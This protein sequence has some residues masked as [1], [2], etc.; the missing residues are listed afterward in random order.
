MITQNS[1]GKNIDMCKPVKLV[2]GEKVMMSKWAFAKWC[3]VTAAV[4][5]VSTQVYASTAS[6]DDACAAAYSGNYNGQDGDG[7][8]GFGAWQVIPTSN[9]GSSGA[10]IGSSQNNGG[11]CNSGNINCN[12]S[13]NKS[14]GMYAN[15]GQASGLR[16]F[17]GG[18]VVGQTFTMEMDNGNI[19][20]PYANN[21]VVEVQLMNASG[22]RRWGVHFRGGAGEYQTYD[23]SNLSFE[24]GTGLGF[25]DGGLRIAFTLTGAN[26]YSVTLTRITA[27]GTVTQTGTLAASGDIDRVFVLVRS[28]GSGCNFDAFWNKM[29]ISACPAGFP[30]CSVTKSSGIDT[31]NTQNTFDAPSGNTSYSWALSAN[32][33]G[34]S[35]SGSSTSPNVTVNNGTTA[36]SYTITVTINN[37]GCISSCSQTITVTDPDVTPPTVTCPPQY[38]AQCGIPAVANSISAFVSQGGTASD[39]G[40]GSL[41]LQH[42]GDTTISGTGCLGSPLVIE[43]VYRVYDGSGNFTDCT[44]LIVLEDTQLP[45]ITC[46]AGAT[47]SCISLLPAVN[48]NLVTASD[49]CGAATVTH[50]GDVQSNPGSSC[51]NTITRTYRATDDCGNFSECTQVF[52]I[53]DTTAPTVACDVNA[54][55]NGGNSAYSDG[56]QNGDNGGTGLGAWTLQKTSGDTGLNGHFMGNSTGNNTAG[57]TNSDGDIGNPAF[58]L[59]ANSGNLSDAWRNFNRLKVG[60]TFKFDFDNCLID[61]GGTVGIGLQN[62]TGGANRMEL[63]FVGGQ[64]NYKLNDGSGVLDTG[65]PFTCEGLRVEVKLLTLDT[66]TITITR[67]VNGAVT[68]ISG[69]SLAGTA[70]SSV[71]RFRVFNF[72]AGAGSS[73]NVLVNNISIDRT[74]RLSCGA[75]APDVTLGLVSSDN[76]GTPTVT[77]SPAV[78]AALPAGNSSITVTVSDSCGN[79]AQCVIPVVVSDTVAPVITCPADITVQCNTSTDPSNTGSATANDACDGAVTPTYTDSTAAGSC[80]FAS[81]IT[82]T[83]S[84][85]DASGN[86]ATCIQT[87]SVV[88]TTAP[89][90]TAPADATLTCTDSTNPSA[91]GT[92]TATDNCDSPA[93]PAP[94]PTAWI[95]EFHYDNTGGDVGEFVEIAGTAGLTFGASCSVVL[96]N[97][98]GGAP[99]LTIPL[100]GMTIPDAGCGIGTISV[101]ATGLQNGAP[102]GI[103]LALC[104]GGTVSEFISYEGTFTAVGGPANGQLSVDVG[105]TQVGTEPVGSSIHKIGTGNTGAAFTWAKTTAG[106]PG[107]ING[108]QTISPCYT[109]GGGGLTVSYSDSTAGTCPIVITR[110]W[111]AT[112]SCGNSGS[113]NQILTIQD[114]TAPTLSGVPANVTVQ[115]SAVP[116]PAT[117]TASDACDASPTV[118]L[119]ES[120]VAGSCAGNYVLTRTWTATDDCGNSAN[121]S[122]VITV[123]DTT[124][125]VLTLPANATV[126]CTGSTDPSATGTA[127][128]SD[129][130]SGA[131][132]SYSDSTAAGSCPQNSVITRTWTATDG[133][134]NVSS[135]NQIINVVDSTDPVVTAPANVTVDCT[136]STDPSNTGSASATDNCDTLAG[137]APTPT[138]W[139]N[140]FHYDNSGTD[141]GEFVEIAGTAGITFGPGCS[142]TFY[143]GSG[144]ASYGSIPLNGLTIPDE[145]CGIGTLSFAAAGLQNGSP[146]GIALALCLGGTVSEFISYEGTFTAVG[147][148]AAGMLSVDVGVTQVGTEPV[149]SSIHRIGSGNTGAAFTWAKTTAG[150]PGSINGGQTISPC[151]TGGG[152]GLTISFSDS[153][154]GTCPAVITRTWTATDACGN[155]GSSV[156]TITVQDTTAPSLTVPANTSVECDGDSSPASTGSASATDNCDASP[157]ITFSDATAAGSCPQASVITRTWTATDACGNSVSG[158][159]VINVVDSTQPVVS[160]PADV[161]VSCTDSIDP[162]ATGS[163]SATDNCDSLALPA[164]PTTAWI[165]EFHYD[166]NSGDVGEFVEVAGT[167]GITFS[168]NCVITLYNGSGGAPYL[169]IPLNGLT[170]PDEGCGYGAISVAAPGLQNGAPDG[171][172]LAL[173]LGGAVAEFISYE[174][175][176]TAV[177]GPANGQTS[178]DVGVSQV[179][180]EPIGSSIHK[181]GS[182]NNGAAF[183]WAKTTAATPGTINGGQTI[184]PCYVTGGGT[185]TISYSDASAGTCPIVVTRTWTATD[186]CGNSGS[187]VQT[188]TIVDDVEPNLSVPAE[189]TVECDSD[190]STA[191][192]GVATATDL[193]DPAPVIASDDDVIPGTCAGQYTIERFWSATDNCGNVAE[194]SQ[195]INVV[196]T[197]APAL[198]VP[199]NVTVECDDDSSPA[200][201]GSASASDNC[202]VAPVISYSDSTVP[203]PCDFTATITRTW[204]AT[205]DCGNESSADQIITVVDTTA[206]VLTVPANIEIE[207]DESSDPSNTGTATA[208]DNC[209]IPGVSYSDSS[210]GTCPT[211]ITRTWTATDA[212]GNSSSAD[213][214]IT[215]GDSFAPV[216]SGCPSGGSVVTFGTDPSWRAS[217]T[218]GSLLGNAQYVCLQSSVPVNC[219]SGA[220]VYNFG[221]GGWGADVSSV[222]G[223]GWIWAPGITASTAPAF[224]AEYNFTK[225]FSLAQL[226]ELA[227]VSMA[228]DDFAEI[229]VNGLPVGSMGSVSDGNLAG[230]AQ[231]LTTFDILPFIVVGQNTITIRA[232]NGN[233]GCGAG[234]YGCNPAGVIAGVKLTYDQSLAVVQTYDC[235]DNVPAPATV[236]AVDACNGVIAVSFTETQSAPGTSCNNTITRTWVATDSCGNSAICSEIINVQDTTAPV[237]NVPADVTVEC[238]DPTDSSATGTATATDNCSAS[239]TITSSDS[240]AEGACPQASII[241]RTWTATDDCGNSSSGVQIINVVD[242]TAPAV[243]APADVTIECTESSAP[244]NTGSGSVTDNCDTFAAPAPAVTAWINEFHY[245]NSGADIG[246]FVEIAGTAGIT[247]GPSC[248][249]TFYNGSG[250]ASYGSIALNGLT[251][252]D[253]G[254]GIG[255][256]SFPAP[257]LQNGSPDGIALALCLGGTV[258]E[259][260]SYEGTFTAVG[261]PAAGQTS[262]DVGVTQTGSEPAGS[263]IHKIGSGNTG[264][265]FTWAKTTAA[266]PGA[267]NGGQTISPCYTGSSG[268]LTLSYSDSTAGTCPTV[269]TRTWTG[270]DG[271]GNVGTADQIIT[272][273]DTTAPILSGVPANTTVECDSIPSA[274]VVTAADAC[275]P[276]PSVNFSET[277]TAGAC[278]NSYTITRTW[279]ATDNCGNSSAGSQVISV[280]DTTGPVLALPANATVECTDSTDPSATGSATATD[281]CAGSVS[282]SYSD[283]TVAGS[284]PQASVITR[285][286]TATDDCGNQTSGSQIIN[287]VDSTD[288]VVTAP[289]DATVECDASI[290]PSATGSATATDNCDSVATDAA[291]LTAWINEFHYDNSGSDVGEFVEIAGTAGITFGPSCSITLYNGSGGAPYS[292]I[293]LN[294]M[295]IPDAGCGFG[296]ISVATPGL[297]NGSPDGIALA[298]C[299]GGTVSEF[300]SYEG[301]FTA[302]GGI[303]NGQTSVDVGVAQTGTEPA[304]SS[305]HKVG[306]G[307]NGA[308]FIWAKTTAATPGAINGGQIISPCYTSGSGTMTITYSD[309]AS[310]TCPTIVTRTWT[311]T[312]GCGNSGSANQIITVVD[313]TAPVISVPADATVECDADNSP[314]ATGSATA[315][316]NC[317]SAPSIS[318]SDVVAEGICPQASVITRTWTA[319]DDCGNT[320]SGVQTIHVV[321]TT[322]PVVV[323]PADVEVSCTDSIAP[324][325]T[326][327]ASATDNCDSIGSPAP[328]LTAW[329]NEFHYD[330]NGT[331]AGEFVEIAGTAGITFGPACQITLYNGSGGASYA[332]YPLN[333]L[334]IPDEGCGYGTIS[335]ATPGLQNGAPDGIALALCLGGTVAEFI[336]YEGTFTAVGGPAAGMLSVDVGVSQTATEPVGSSIHRIGSGNTGTNFTWAKTTANSSG[337][338]NVGQSIAPC[339]V[340][341]GG[342]LILTYSDSSAGACPE[343]VTRT[344]TAT[345][346]CGNVGTAV[347]TITIV[348]ENEPLL[349]VPAEVTVECDSDTSAAATGFA[350]AT[351]NCDSSPIIES[352][353]DVV[354]G[355]CAGQYTIERFWSAKDSCGNVAEASQIINVVDTTAPVLTVPADVTVECSDDSSPAGT[356]SAT[357][358]DNCGTVD[359]T[360]SDS[361]AAGPCDFTATIT[362]TWTATDDCGNSVSADQI[363]TV[364]DTTAPVVTV[365]ADVTIECDESSDPSNTGS[366]TA[367]DNCDTP[368]ITYSD[369]VAGSCPSVITRTW[370]ATDA[371][372]NSSSADQII[373]VVDTTAPSLSVPAD[374]TVECTGDTSPAATGSA[375]GSD[376]CGSVTITSSDSS[377]SGCGDTETITRTWTATDE[378]GNS[379][380]A[381]QVI[382]VVDT[383]A[384]SISVPADATVECTG[385]TSP[386][387]TGSAT[388]SDSCGSVTITSSDSSV[389]GCGDT[390]TITRT[391]TATDECGNSTSADQIITVVDTTAPSLSVP[392]DATVECTG[393]TSPAATGSATGSDSCGSVTITSSDSSVAGCGNTETITRTWT[394]TDECGNS[395]SAD[396]VITVVDT[397]APSLSV[398]ADATVECTGDTS[399][400]GTG[401]ATGSDSCGSVTIT[402]SDSSVAGCGSSETIT[403]TWTA[404]DEC[405][406]STSADQII[407]VVDTTAPSISVPA[408]ATVECTGDT[409]PAATGSAT[410]SDSCGSVTITSSDSSVA[411]CGDTETITR[412][413]TATDACGNSTS[414]DQVITVVDTTA[415][416]IS[417]PADATVE[418]TGDT[419]P[420]STGSATG[421]DSCGSVTISSSDSSVAGCGNTETITRTWTAT[422]ACGNTASAVQTITV[423]DTTA[424]SISVP[425]DATVE[426]T[427]DTSPASTGSAT[428]S[429]SCGSVTI[430]SSDSSVAGCGNSATITRTWTATDACGNTASAAQTITVVDTTAPTLIGVP[431]NT[432]VECDAV[433]APAGVT[434]SDTCGSAT[435]SFSQSSSGTCPTV[436]TRTWTATDACGN[437]ASASQ[438]ITVQDTTA[439]V[440][441][442]PANVTAICAPGASDPASSGYATA[443]DNCGTATV[444]YSDSISG[445]CPNSVI[446]RTWTATDE[447]GNSSSCQQIITLSDTAKPIL[448]GCPADIVIRPCDPIPAPAT[449]T[450]VDACQGALTVTYSQVTVT[451]RIENE[452]DNSSNSSDS[453]D[454]NDGCG[455]HT[456][457]TLILRTWTATDACG[458]SA[459]CSQ[460]ITVNNLGNCVFSHGYWKTH[461]SEWPVTSLTLGCTTYNQSQL[462]GI[463]NSPNKGD[464]SISLAQQLIAALLNQAA[465][466]C[467]RS[468]VQASIDSAMSLLCTKPV[469][470]NPSGSI[471]NQMNSAACLLDDF[472]NGKKGNKKCS[473]APN[474]P[475]VAMDDMETTAQNT[476]VIISILDNDM[477]ADN[478]SLAVLYVTNPSSGTLTI[479]ANGTIT[480]TPNNGYV[481]SDS[482]TYVVS[483]GRGGYESAVV[484]VFVQAGVPPPSSGSCTDD[485]QSCLARSTVYFTS[486][487]SSG[488]SK[489]VSFEGTVTLTD[490]NLASDFRN[491]A[492][493]A[494]G[495]LKVKVAGNEIYN[496]VAVPYA[497]IG[498]DPVANSEKWEFIAG[499]Y[500]KVTFLWKDS[501]AYDANRDPGLPSNLGKFFTRFIHA[502]ETEFRFEWKSSTKKPLLIVVDGIVI[503]KRDSSGNVSSTLPN[504]KSSS[505]IDVTYPARLVP[506]NTISWYQDSNPNDGF[507]NLIYSHEATADGISA[508]T[509]FN[510]GGQFWMTLPVAGLSINSANKTA[511]AELT[512]GKTTITLVGCTEFEVG[513]YAKSGKSW[514]YQD[515]CQDCNSDDDSS[516]NDSH[517]NNCNNHCGHYGHH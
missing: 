2:S 125:P 325:A 446:T 411:G 450:A 372:G 137:P 383:T 12:T 386:A 14:W 448:S 195:I 223:A 90:V 345:D 497:V 501:Q 436:I 109:G 272:V 102:D 402:S 398:P 311:A 75:T 395:T 96:Y 31:A 364:V 394:A 462:L 432:S 365:P 469:G 66:Y 379:T 146:D 37:N 416:S 143:N 178:V 302:V 321:D 301:T 429:D 268:S 121:A 69:R 7:A 305:I 406:N 493:T 500:E 317:D 373:T 297:Q 499:A 149:G 259:F 437:T 171:I 119:S 303:A 289:A 238:T 328:A 427:G 250:G 228:A 368:G 173:C 166:N 216:L 55:D 275:D 197:T 375:T 141:V 487:S 291:P 511:E 468:D 399:P 123:Q 455:R 316:D 327:N 388:G 203:G 294:G 103:A 47:L 213:Q 128:A 237:L 371:C 82:R 508:D 127:T 349:V 6:Y 130:C 336:S 293:S 261:G 152:G 226:P 341:S 385:D 181:I 210:S 494:Q 200:G 57:D 11:G 225:K 467:V 505:R 380:S 252:P 83:W 59:Y 488:A 53:N 193:C 254:C 145:G 72:N 281:N 278:A 480:Y 93:T 306:S 151:F 332:S 139:I 242:T 300:I 363:I 256:L 367:T 73:R 231:V 378:C 451:N 517:D 257:G 474:H 403:R 391:W 142:I 32:T 81:T 33:S 334:T 443:T 485:I 211:V 221:S 63:Y 346:G 44:Q 94:T 461:A 265:A 191:A 220:L 205:D 95:N 498:A 377:V 1:I 483:D 174:G 482:F 355:S 315:T 101:A 3:A 439:P 229:I 99:Y 67:L 477:D 28:A 471:R 76:C 9:G 280:V 270:T 20:G 322:D 113:A 116:A 277:T 212:C 276:N 428:G 196:D 245:D 417:V 131:S 292:T 233:F 158:D 507:Q 387:A 329:I 15:S 35:I 97:G 453:S 320:A 424:P 330:N 464:A 85:T 362:R 426:C 490:G 179:G 431:A 344:W 155:S 447:C 438:V 504:S 100:S 361:V 107:A 23:A 48:V 22:V 506:G 430:T 401:S 243:T 495:S 407:T 484:C 114:V 366:A 112:D 309:S 409:S 115:C 183:T 79:S 189:I 207:C 105:V 40:P 68:T 78:G 358:S 283:S 304:G 359:V 50:Q 414:A 60:Q 209:D 299:L 452:D 134:G 24:R 204:T 185:L 492:S 253:E 36:G 356:G 118:T 16:T 515:D 442:C 163:A 49:N 267:I 286:W 347:Q 264:A 156:Q 84:A 353:D 298:L 160:A 269:I 491:N 314:A 422:D 296:T 425:A 92:A 219:P 396:Q 136:D 454:D 489:Y 263:S 190:T 441:T 260:I 162:S 43:R 227:T 147:G 444:T 370:T 307:N 323:A 153:T 64:P 473:S 351:D 465:G 21:N 249:I 41:S 89:V 481:G 129:N 516:D 54:A 486:S 187:S 343:V 91:T 476:P 475:P 25:T 331:D 319:T 192:T 449:V 352:D 419:S 357:A 354:P 198:T 45:V 333:G 148:P 313:T 360:S 290:D 224:P 133:C 26:T 235:I 246:E 34:A 169:T 111:T 410:G 182:G 46:P 98:S 232:A 180:T 194:A 214:I 369:S 104:V 445:N 240:T 140:E 175:T 88:D 58:G 248:T 19:N 201:T 496:N 413:W 18:L 188:I 282:I 86:T 13:G 418:C 230:N 434:A 350:T 255:T 87:I 262:V 138:A 206:P 384:P 397:T 503:A 502:T 466:A 52:V 39:S 77:Q 170:I 478:D 62:S 4:L 120:T 5:S 150:T 132:V 108:G 222:P 339:Y 122:Q 273:Q 509:Y 337:S 239:V 217:N 186:G 412:T 338:L 8:G 117:V 324:S 433:P 440:I 381:D 335:V 42:L 274:P 460:V 161:E 164:P 241:T 17:S 168:S 144:G 176:F 51:N 310:G 106:T 415:P 271:C 167:A 285:T 177:G 208:T 61:T 124:A 479:N 199:A 218:S 27:G 247:F 288:P 342:T 244:S 251:I 435:V 10:F 74:V 184:S 157:V 390:E 513:S 458:N 326:G 126:E 376:N 340:A 38:N 284:C 135:G 65:I 29:Q 312:D 405:G 70:G 258:S 110:T 512:I 393:D 159:Q 457:N 459:S 456:G 279:T 71:N 348:D 420:A 215:V 389:S 308:A 400:A 404:T 318:H 30:A 392:A 234:A 287:V 154:S 514:N 408:D 80:P 421:S 374:A 470:S 382:T 266:T 510:A 236:T 56:W 165:N 295:T 472:N 172:A 463:L 423:V 202:D